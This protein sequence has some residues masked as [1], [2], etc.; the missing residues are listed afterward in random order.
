[1]SKDWKCFLFD[2]M[3]IHILS[4]NI[5]YKNVSFKD[6]NILARNIRTIFYLVSI[7]NV[8][9]ICETKCVYQFWIQYRL[10]AFYH[11]H[12]LHHQSINEKRPINKEEKPLHFL[13][14]TLHTIWYLI[15]VTHLYLNLVYCYVN[16]KQSNVIFKS[17][18]LPT[19]VTRHFLF[20]LLI[21][22]CFHLMTL[23]TNTWTYDSDLFWT[24]LFRKI[25]FQ[26]DNF[27]L[28]F[29]CRI[30]LHRWQ[31]N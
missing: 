17:N 12:L 22:C 1:M 26:H 8:L 10:N 30:F 25:I 4:L 27:I 3:E 2:I 23:W 6:M 15:T 28:W 14:L 24:S 11:V 16:K 7:K 20:P 9:I 21:F 29:K 19:G 18:F 5:T 13:Y 31:N